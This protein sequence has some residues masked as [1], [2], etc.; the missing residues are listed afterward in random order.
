[1][2]PVRLCSHHDGILV[3]GVVHDA[4]RYGTQDG[5]ILLYPCS[6]I[7]S[8][9]YQGAPFQLF[10]LPHILALGVIMLLN[11]SLVYVRTVPDVPGYAALPKVLA[12][13]LL[14]NDAAY[15]LWLWA[16]GFWSLQYSLPLHMCSVM[17]I[18]SAMTLLTGSRRL[19]PYTYFLGI[20]GAMQAL[21]TPPLTYYG[22][23]HYLFFQ[24]FISH[25]LIVTAAL[26]MTIVRGYRPTLR[27]LWQVLVGTHLYMVVVAG[28]N[29]LL[30][31]NY[32]FLARKPDVV[33]LLDV[34]APWP[35]YL[36]WMEAL[37]LV[38]I[39]VLYLPF[40]LSDWRRAR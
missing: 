5:G 23:P 36:L 21:L 6:N 13:V 22:F 30:G 31:S 28:V 39:G 27:S 3:S 15:H 4:H 18:V 16:N 25:G 9:D 33:T 24:T 1:M 20:G 34:L 40:A 10:A 32:M 8:V 26:Y 11:L 2:L 35:W 37:G 17:V 12:G 14:V 7:F 38:V 19:Y 29:M